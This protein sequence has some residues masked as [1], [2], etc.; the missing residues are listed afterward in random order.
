MFQASV[1]GSEASGSRS[2]FIAAQGFRVYSVGR[3]LS[4]TGVFLVCCRRPVD[5]ND[6]IT[7]IEHWHC[8]NCGGLPRHMHPRPPAAKRARVPFGPDLAVATETLI[9][10]RGSATGHQSGGWGGHWPIRT[11]MSQPATGK[12]KEAMEPPINTPS[13]CDVQP[14]APKRHTG[15]RHTGSSYHNPGGGNGSADMPQV[16][17]NR[18]RP[19]GAK[20]KCA[21]GYR[22]HTT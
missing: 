15:P 1:E 4:P 19:T 21:N 8:E 3:F 5:A 6:A 22:G 16:T 17:G 14:P 11:E 18:G 10:Q 13:L 7:D 12:G 20:P 2:H 9:N